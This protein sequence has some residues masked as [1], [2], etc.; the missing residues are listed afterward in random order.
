MVALRYTNV[1]RWV[2]E[3]FCNGCGQLR[4]ALWHRPKRC[5]HCGSEDINIA[6]AG[7]LDKEKLKDE[8]NDQS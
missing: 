2:L 5:M 1:N 3:Y 6:A 8:F 4:L 7:T